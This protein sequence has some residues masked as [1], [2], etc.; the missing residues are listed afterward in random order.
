MHWNTPFNALYLTAW[1]G[2]RANFP[3]KPYYYHSD[4]ENIDFKVFDEKL[5]HAKDEKSKKKRLQMFKAMDPNGNG[6]LS[7]A[8][9]RAVLVGGIKP[10][11]LLK[12]PII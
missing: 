10:R 3:I 8:E 4:I 6:Y 5:P 2:Q 9:V 12:S 11:I 1:H 7:L